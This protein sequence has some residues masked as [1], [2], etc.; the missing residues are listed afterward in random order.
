[1]LDLY[2]AG[3][4][5]EP[6]C[7][8]LGYQASPKPSAPSMHPM[9]IARRLLPEPL[10]IAISRHFPRDVRERL[11]SDQFRAATD[12]SR[13]T[14]F[15]LPSA[16][17][18]FIRVNLRG[19]DPQGTVSAGAEYEA[20]LDRIEADLWKLT[21]PETGECPIAS[22]TRTTRVF[23]PA[24]PHLPDVL[25]EW[26]PSRR[27]I[28]RL[29]HPAGDIHQKKPEFFRDSDH[30]RVGFVAAA[31][32]SIQPGDIGAISPLDLAPTFLA[33]L[34]R[35]TRA[36]VGPARAD[37]GPNFS[38]AGGSANNNPLLRHVTLPAS[39]VPEPAASPR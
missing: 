2:P 37:V 4:L 30:S 16:Y 8:V 25:V 19:R 33:L 27:F 29:A 31:G 34:A 26:K 32:P 7:R 20:L 10:R 24:S 17:T 22:V 14:A 15:A 12:W 1:M 18:G 38:S 28:D 36:D 9:A 3:D 39:L 11:M 21:D 35:P 5:M 23:S 6:F 13:T